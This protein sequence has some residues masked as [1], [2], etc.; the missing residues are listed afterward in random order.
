VRHTTHAKVSA[1]DIA[2]AGQALFNMVAGESSQKD[3]GL[4]Q[5]TYRLTLSNKQYDLPLTLTLERRGPM[6]ITILQYV[7]LLPDNPVLTGNK[8]SMARLGQLTAEITK[9]LT[10]QGHHNMAGHLAIFMHELQTEFDKKWVTSNSDAKLL[11]SLYEELPALKLVPD[12]ERNRILN[13]VAKQFPI[14]M[15]RITGRRTVSID[16]STPI[17]DLAAWA[18]SRST[19]VDRLFYLLPDYLKRR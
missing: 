14:E 15:E 3:S 12:S 11:A 10:E 19:L 17:V 8:Q 1:N 5:Y 18:A 16:P 2:T 9:Q 6:Y 7:G 4:Q 13:S